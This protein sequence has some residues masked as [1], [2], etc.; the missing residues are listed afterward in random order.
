MYTQFCRSTLAFIP[1]VSF[2]FCPTFFNFSACHRCVGFCL[3][4]C[5][6]CYGGAVNYTVSLALP[7]HRT[8][9]A[10]I[11]WGL[12]LQLLFRKSLPPL[13][14]TFLENGGLN[15]VTDFFLHFFLVVHSAGGSYFN[16][17][18]YPLKLNSVQRVPTV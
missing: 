4:R 13:L 1:C 5:C 14:I 7:L 2:I 17:C 15:L 3:P 10:F 11:S 16:S 18:L 9:K 12:H 8:V 6:L